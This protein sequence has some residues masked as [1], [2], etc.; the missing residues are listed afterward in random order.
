MLTQRLGCIVESTMLAIDT[1]QC[2]IAVHLAAVECKLSPSEIPN[3]Q[4]R[5]RGQR[6]G[7]TACAVVCE[8]GTLGLMPAPDFWHS[9]A[10]ELGVDS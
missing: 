6:G 1:E 2:V 10:E 7:R 4:E 5:K 9:V 8:E 3:E